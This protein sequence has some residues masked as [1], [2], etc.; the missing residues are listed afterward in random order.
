[1]RKD[2]PVNVLSNDLRN[3]EDTIDK[4]AAMIN[5]SG[6]NRSQRRRL[7]KALCRT[8]KLTERAQ[9]QLDHSA[10]KEYQAAVDKNFVHFFA[11][12]GLCMMEHYNWKETPDNDHG[13]LTS[14]F[15]R[16]TK[17]LQKYH[18][19]GYETEDLVKL[20]DEKTGILLVPD[21]R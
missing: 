9:K 16:L 13:Q 14:L 10:Y 17:T 8:Q 21:S 18:D 15:E 7:E 3:D 5:N 4:V 12:L 2:I 20:L 19:M 11:A 6:Y 1:M